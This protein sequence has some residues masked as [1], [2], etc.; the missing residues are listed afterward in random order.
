MQKAFGNFQDNYG[1]A[2]PGATITVYDSGTTDLATIYSDDGV[3]LISG[4]SF[5]ADANGQWFF[6]APDGDYDVKQEKS[7]F[8]S[9]TK[10]D[11]QLLDRTA[12]KSSLMSLTGYSFIQGITPSATTAG[13]WWLDSNTGNVYKSSG[14][15]S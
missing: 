12:V 5:S 10:V 9:V 8:T 3:T 7:G 11:L 6:Y 13:Q 1:N 4:S 15:G 14:T 2:I